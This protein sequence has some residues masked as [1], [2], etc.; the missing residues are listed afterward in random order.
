MSVG[1][2]IKIFLIVFLLVLLAKTLK[3]ISDWLAKKLVDKLYE[4]KPVEIFS[5]FAVFITAMPIFFV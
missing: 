2:S 1:E 3:D 5:F 4:A